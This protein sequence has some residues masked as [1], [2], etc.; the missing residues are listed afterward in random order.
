MT[1]ATTDIAQREISG[2]RAEVLTLFEAAQYL[3]VPEAEILELVRG[4]DLPGRRIG[5][6]W[7]F[8]KAALQDWLRSAEKRDFW[9]THF[10][11]L[12]DD[13]YLEEILKRV[14]DERAQA[15]A[16]DE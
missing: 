9:S 5:D 1:Q 15:T 12:K 6:Q 4:R 14:A 16:E 8:L 2:E 3:R 11:S 10:G 13:P 7:R